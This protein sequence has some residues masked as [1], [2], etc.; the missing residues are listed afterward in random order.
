MNHLELTDTKIFKKISDSS[1]KIN[2]IILGRK[3]RKG[4]PMSIKMRRALQHAILFRKGSVILLNEFL[5]A[6]VHWV[7]Q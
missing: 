5:F 1:L 4:K 2:W 3:S 6:P 7:G